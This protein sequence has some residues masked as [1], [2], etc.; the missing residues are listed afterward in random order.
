M[1]LVTH[2]L[3]IAA[4]GLGTAGAA[5]AQ[6]PLARGAVDQIGS[7]Q[8]VGMQQVGRRAMSGDAAS[9]PAPQLSSVAESV[10]PALQLTRERGSGPAS[11]QL[12]RGPRTAQ[13]SQALSTPAEGRT[14]TVERVA[15][16]DR[17]DPAAAQP[18]KPAKCAAVIETRAAEF[19]RRAPAPLS[20]E[21]RIIV[22]QQARERSV[23]FSSAAR[24][25]AVNADDARS[26]EA[27]GVASLV[28][29]A[30]SPEPRRETP[31]EDPAAS[32]QFNALVNAIVNQ[33]PQR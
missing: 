1:K 26:I 27:Q 6:D 21:Q 9:A 2:Y 4:L 8:P 16:S 23:S 18:A 11:Q 24:R 29:G 5:A 3:T 30:P 13:P 20:P 32:E 31:V 25:L 14:G 19:T 22:E 17:C 12:T 15:G 7:P 28:L 33:P 10:T